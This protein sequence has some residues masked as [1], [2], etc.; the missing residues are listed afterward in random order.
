M[1]R[2]PEKK[3]FESLLVPILDFLLGLAMQL[4]RSRPHAEDLVQDAVLKAYRSFSSFE[5][6]S[7]FRAWVARILT[8]TFLTTQERAKRFVQGV[9]PDEMPDSAADHS[10]PEGEEPVRSL[11][12]IPRDALGDKV[13][14]ALRELPA[15]MAL[16]VYLADVEELPY[17]EI[18]EILDIPVGT[19][20]SRVSRGRRHLQRH[21]M[22]HARQLGY[23]AKKGS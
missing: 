22:S 21:L 9:D 2:R 5:P 8:N 18:G 23:A 17:T 4:T 7:N 15:G 11:E 16:A 12:D 20:R 10:P 19:V 6:G 3:R 13:M 1:S 14:A